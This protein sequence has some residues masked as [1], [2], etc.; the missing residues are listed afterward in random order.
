LPGLWW[1]FWNM[2][3]SLSTIIKAAVN[4]LSLQGGEIFDA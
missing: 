3:E 2:Y 4:K 1:K